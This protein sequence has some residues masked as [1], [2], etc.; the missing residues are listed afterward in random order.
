MG[1]CWRWFIPL[2]SAPSEVAPFTSL[3]G[4]A[5]ARISFL[6]D[7]IMNE[8][9]NRFNSAEVIGRVHMPVLIVQ[10][11]KDRLVS[12]S[13]TRAL[14]AVAP[15]PKTWVEVSDAG[16]NDVFDQPDFWQSVE[17]FVRGAVR[18]R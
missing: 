8:H 9:E 2:S 14:F 16:H 12:P 13:D 1:C 3:L 18:C 4:A 10:A 5:R 6:A 11:S 15:H 7:L 17:R